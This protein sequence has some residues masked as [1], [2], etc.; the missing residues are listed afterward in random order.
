MLGI[1]PTA[2]CLLPTQNTEGSV[3]SIAK[4][5][6]TNFFKI[7]VNVYLYEQMFDKMTAPNAFRFSK[8]L[9][10]KRLQKGIFN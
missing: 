10:I 5:F 6:Q 7:K 3:F 4:D 9:T 2:N 1:L 8:P